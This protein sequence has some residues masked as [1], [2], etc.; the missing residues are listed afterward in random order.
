MPRIRLLKPQFFVNDSLGECDPL[1]R[2]LFMGLWCL[3]DATGRLEYRPVRIKAQ[4]LPYDKCDVDRLV[5]QLEAHGFVR[6]YL[7]AGIPILQICK[8]AEHQRPHP[9]EPKNVFPAEEFSTGEVSFTEPEKEISCR[10]NKLQ[11]LTVCPLSLSL[12]LSLEDKSRSDS[13]TLPLKRQS[14]TEPISW[15]VE[16]GWLG[17]S[18]KDRECWSKA[19]PA[20][21][22]ETEL[23][24]GSEWLKANPTKAH[25]KNWRKFLT[26]WLSRCQDGGGTTRG[27]GIRAAHNAPERP[28]RPF[29]GEAA[30]LHRAGME[31][32][33]REQIRR[34]QEDLQSRELDKIVSS[35]RV[36]GEIE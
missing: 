27:A 24:K 23:A 17:I 22:L 9:Q 18:D 21:T 30:A 7:V 10:E 28:C 36:S 3:A 33:R 1:A 14:K 29:S 19:Y 20:A 13:L 12:S 25:R 35:I 16:E 4:L 32:L 15:S 11:E 8:F 2:L 34:D 26:G 5:G 31:K 6:T